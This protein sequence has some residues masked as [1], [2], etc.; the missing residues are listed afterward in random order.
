MLVPIIFF[1][2]PGGVKTLLRIIGKIFLYNFISKKYLKQKVVGL[3]CLFL[4]C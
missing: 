3:S 4:N 2:S 1:N